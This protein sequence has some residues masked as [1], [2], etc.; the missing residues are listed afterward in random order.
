MPARKKTSRVSPAISNNPI[1]VEYNE[2]ENGDAFLYLG[3]LWM[4]CEVGDQEAINLETGCIEEDM[5][6]EKVEKVNVSI[7][8]TRK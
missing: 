3:K 8:W 4:K 6:D 7:A 2:L 1:F 5:C